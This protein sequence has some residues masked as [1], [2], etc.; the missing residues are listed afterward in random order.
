VRQAAWNHS[1]LI[2][3]ETLATTINVDEQGK[4]SGAETTVGN[5]ETAIVVVARA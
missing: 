2:G 3:G 1:R 4:A 5:G